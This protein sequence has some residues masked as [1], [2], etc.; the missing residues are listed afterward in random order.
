M[1]TEQWLEE[2]V[3]KVVFTTKDGQCQGGQ[4]DSPPPDTHQIPLDED[5]T[6]DESQQKGEGEGEGEGE[7]DNGEDQLAQE[8]QELM[9]GMK[10]EGTVSCGSVEA[11]AENQEEDL[12][13]MDD[14][15]ANEVI[16]EIEDEVAEKGGE[17]HPFRGGQPGKGN[18]GSSDFELDIPEVKRL[19]AW[20]KLIRE[21][22]QREFE[23][24][25][26]KKEF[27]A[28]L[29]FSYGFTQRG[30]VKAPE[31]RKH[32][33]IMADVSGSMM[34][35]VKGTGESLLEQLLAF[36]PRLT[37]DYTAE[38]WFV[39]S[40]L[41]TK[42][43]G[44]DAIYTPNELDDLTQAEF[45]EFLDKAQKETGWGGGTSFTRPFEQMLEQ[46]KEDG[47]EGVVIALTDTDFHVK[48]IPKNTIILTDKSNKGGLSSR[49][50]KELADDDLNFHI[51]DYE[52]ES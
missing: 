18:T 48:P 38:L 25:K 22:A 17:S 34:W 1:A 46:R 24:E 5:Q 52:K 31:F 32:M 43:D 6:Q 30:K 45:L 41:L 21:F 12:D 14:M 50:K 35:D 47:D 42:E 44:S 3:Q 11:S 28:P 49:Y 51:L 15:A 19:P 7:G 8:A 27:D 37:K 4:C 40:G 9:D 2:E 26:G 20:V 23:K 10:D 16:Q 13:F 39:S 29:S 33:Y 36:I